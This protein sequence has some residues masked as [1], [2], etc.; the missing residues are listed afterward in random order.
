MS[1]SISWLSSVSCWLLF[2]ASRGDLRSSGFP[3]SKARQLSWCHVCLLPEER[4]ITFLSP[5][6]TDPGVHLIVWAPATGSL[7]LSLQK[8]ELR[9]AIRLKSGS[10][11]IPYRPCGMR[12]VEGKSLNKDLRPWL[13]K[14]GKN[15]GRINTSDDKFPK[16]SKSWSRG[17]SSIKLTKLCMKCSTWMPKVILTSSGVK[18]TLVNQKLSGNQ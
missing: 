5:A 16:C 18:K 9:R 8:K 13:K 1:L 17:R 4:V 15:V 14:R 10:C 6:H 12:V 3:V 11:T 7:S 2:L